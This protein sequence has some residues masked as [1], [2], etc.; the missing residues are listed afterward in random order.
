MSKG[1]SKNPV[2]LLLDA[3]RV[4]MTANAYHGYGTPIGHKDPDTGE[5][6]IDCIVIAGS[7]E[8]V[9]RYLSHIVPD[10]KFD[11]EKVQKVSVFGTAATSVDE[12]L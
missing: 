3:A 4:P 9:K 12:E 6:S 2:P 11:A 1:K 7:V 5:I 10:H 8:D